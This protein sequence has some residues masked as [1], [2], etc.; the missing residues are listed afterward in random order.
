MSRSSFTALFTTADKLLFLVS[1]SLIVFSYV[2]FWQTSP[3]SYAIVKSGQQDSR[4]INLNESKI[5]QVEGRLG[6][7]KLEVKDGQIRFISSAC[8]NK[9]CIQSGWHQHGGAVTACLPNRV[10]VQL[11]RQT[12]QTDYDAIIF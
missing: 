8:K 4:L 10:S 3:A 6:I 1:L 7:S 12:S 9:I 5:H 2:Y 11:G